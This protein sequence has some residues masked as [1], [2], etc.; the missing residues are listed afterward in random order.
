[1][2]MFAPSI[3]GHLADA[4][5]RHIG[6]RVQRSGRKDSEN[7]PGFAGARA[8]L[9]VGGGGHGNQG[10]EEGKSAHSPVILSRGH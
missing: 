2:R 3:D 4:N 8:V 1:M 7:D 10:S 5:A 9:G 6:D